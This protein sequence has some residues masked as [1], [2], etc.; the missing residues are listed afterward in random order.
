M[1]FLC[2]GLCELFALFLF[3]FKSEVLS[4]ENIITSGCLAN[5]YLLLTVFAFGVLK[6]LEREI[7]SLSTSPLSPTGGDLFLSCFNMCYLC[8]ILLNGH[9]NL[10]FLTSFTGCVLIHVLLWLITDI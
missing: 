4:G 1:D 9:R 6:L 10:Q 2:F 5:L 3:M 7:L 8:C